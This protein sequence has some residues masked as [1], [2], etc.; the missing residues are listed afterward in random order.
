MSQNAKSQGRFHNPKVGSSIL[1]P[2]TNSFNDL[3]VTAI[4]RRGA[5]CPF[6]VHPSEMQ[7]ELL[8][9][10]PAPSLGR[11]V[12]SLCCLPL[13]SRLRNGAAIAHAIK[14]QLIMEVFVPAFLSRTFLTFALSRIDSEFD[15]GPPL[16][17]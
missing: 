10:W 6:C 5:G 4:Q 9:F 3:R 14:P 1:P 8:L 11:N 7:T 16:S 12:L 2:A 15:L 13:C 17:T